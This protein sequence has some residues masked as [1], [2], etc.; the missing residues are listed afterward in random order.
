MAT[1]NLVSHESGV[2]AELKQMSH[3]PRNPSVSLKSM[4]EHRTYPACDSHW[5]FSALGRSS[6]TL[7]NESIAVLKLLLT[8]FPEMGF[9]KVLLVSIF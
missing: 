5:S 7:S 8:R 9:C 6:G 1:V 3:G 2:P 4:T